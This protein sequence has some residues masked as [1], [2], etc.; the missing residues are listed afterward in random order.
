MLFGAP[1]S[2]TGLTSDQCRPS[3]GCGGEVWTAP[4][5]DAARIERLRAWTLENEPSLLGANPYD[6][7]A[8]DVPSDAVC[9]VLVVDATTRAYRLETFANESD[10]NAAGGVVTHK[11]IC[12]QCSSLHDLAVYAETLDL[13]TPVRQ[14]GISHADLEGDIGCLRELGFSDACAEIWAYNTLHTRQ[15]CASICVPLLSA[16]YHDA[17]GSLNACLQ[18]DE[19]Q[20]GAVFKAVAGRT[21]RNTGIAS[22]LCRPCSEVVRLEHRYEP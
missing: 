7:A 1:E 12:G 17:D 2:T 5:W 3:C 9:A 13:T 6:V 20:S 21:R 19:D 18:C 4:T 16:P 22:A 15:Q 8:P 11:G 14:C 10:A